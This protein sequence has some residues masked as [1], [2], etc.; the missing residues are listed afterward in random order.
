MGITAAGALKETLKNVTGQETQPATQAEKTD[1]KQDSGFMLPVL[2][3]AAVL[4]AG[5]AA[6]GIILYRK[7]RR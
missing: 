2:I 7:K 6:A 3:G 1:E 5:A 4:V